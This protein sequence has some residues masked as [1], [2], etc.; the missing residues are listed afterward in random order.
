MAEQLSLSMP[1]PTGYCEGIKWKPDLWPAHIT[2]Q[3]GRKWAVLH[4]GGIPTNEQ[5]ARFLCHNPKN[6][7]YHQIKDSEAYPA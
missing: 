3:S 2:D 6:V 7:E 5:P 1:Y 4:V